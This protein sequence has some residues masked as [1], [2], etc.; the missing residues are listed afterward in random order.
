MQSWSFT[1]TLSS[2]KVSL[3]IATFMLVSAS[4]YFPG[5]FQSLGLFGGLTVSEKLIPSYLRRL[6]VSV[7]VSNCLV[8]LA[9]PGCW[10][11]PV[12]AS[13]DLALAF[14]NLRLAHPANAFFARRSSPILGT[15]L[16]GLLL[17]QVC[18]RCRL[19]VAVY[20]C[21]R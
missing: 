7:G 15:S 20:L 11:P 5:P 2:G 14:F 1:V 17:L 6:G 13:L 4:L 12:P 3:K 8:K 19:P 18:R 21:H 16:H 10:M 9:V